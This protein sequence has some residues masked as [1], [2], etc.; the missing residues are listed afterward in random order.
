[1]WTTEILSWGKNNIFPSPQNKI[2]QR[3]YILF[4]VRMK[5]LHSFFIS[6]T[7]ETDKNITCLN[8]SFSLISDSLGLKLLFH[9]INSLNGRKKYI[10]ISHELQFIYNVYIVRRCNT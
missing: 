1:M 10:W 6:I 2:S 9:N 4:F 8:K 7:Y 5:I 3:W